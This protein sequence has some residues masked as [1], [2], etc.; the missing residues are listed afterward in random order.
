MLVGGIDQK[1]VGAILKT[2][3]TYFMHQHLCF[4][5]YTFFVS[6]RPFLPLVKNGYIPPDFEEISF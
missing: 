6:V 4:L 3:L 1:T 2:F 5:F